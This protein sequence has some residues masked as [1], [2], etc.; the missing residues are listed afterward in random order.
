VPQASIFVT[1]NKMREQLDAMITR[2]RSP[3]AFLTRVAYPMYVVRQSK[4]WMSEG[5]SEGA[6]WAPLNEKYAKW[7]ELNFAG[8][9]GHGKKILIRTGLLAEAVIGRK[10]KGDVVSDA[11]NASP[12]KPAHHFV[13]ITKKQLHVYTDL[14]YAKYVDQSR[15]IWRFGDDFKKRL[16]A[17]YKSWFAT[18]SVRLG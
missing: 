6:K 8:Y 7:K 12:D 13:A 10:L 17:L 11:A 15:S 2:A 16:R 9:P 18:G 3:E 1:K 5:A 4:R 14:E